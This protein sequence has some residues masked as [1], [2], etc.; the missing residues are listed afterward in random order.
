MV[1][2][3]VTV[4]ICEQKRP[5]LKPSPHNTFPSTSGSPIKQHSVFTAIRWA[6][7]PRKSKQNI[8]QMERM[9]IR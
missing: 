7:K 5:W 1:Y 9:R 8:M 4:L 6:S 2:N 3:E